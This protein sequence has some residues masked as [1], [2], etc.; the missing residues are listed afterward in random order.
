M[1]L[2]HFQVKILNKHFETTLKTCLTLTRKIFHLTPTG[3]IF[4]N[5]LVDFIHTNAMKP[6]SKLTTRDDLWKS[7]TN[8]CHFL[9]EFES[10]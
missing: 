2:N 4:Q 8:F 5:R 9:R 3:K 10:P 6:F 7:V 1:S